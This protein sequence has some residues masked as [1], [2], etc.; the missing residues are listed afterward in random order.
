M[1]R[2]NT[3]R[4]KR[5]DDRDSKNEVILPDGRKLTRRPTENLG[6]QGLKLSAPKKE[7]FER[8]WVSDATDHKVQY[9]IDLGWTPA[10][11]ENGKQFDPRRGGNRVDGKS[12]DMFLM[13]IPT[14]ELER[15]KQK[16]KE[17]DPTAMALENQ[18]KWIEGQS[19]DGLETYNVQSDG[20]AYN[21]VKEVE[22]K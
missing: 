5:D 15:L 17:L 18:Q 11:D 8:R 3:S 20:K 6:Q 21:K 7:G 2:E 4:N 12:F 14:K 16:H 9:M 10:T 1:T 22:F 19:V 13:E